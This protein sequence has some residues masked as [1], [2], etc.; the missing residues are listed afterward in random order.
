MARQVTSQEWG[1]IIAMAWLDPGFSRELSTDPAKAVKR[2]LHLEHTTEV[3]ILQVPAKPEDLSRP[4]L[5]DI[6][7]GRTLNAYQPMF[8]C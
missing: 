6:R 4:Q 2:F 8:S 5:E 7:D 1:R 3:E